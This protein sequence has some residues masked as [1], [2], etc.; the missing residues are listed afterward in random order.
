M[1]K[2]ALPLLAVVIGTVS[3]LALTPARSGAG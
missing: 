3:W 1:R 2:E